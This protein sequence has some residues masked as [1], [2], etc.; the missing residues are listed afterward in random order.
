MFLSIKDENVYYTVHMLSNIMRMMM[1]MN[2]SE[3]INEI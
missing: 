2:T 3:V 1:D